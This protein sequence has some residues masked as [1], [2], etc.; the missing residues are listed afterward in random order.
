MISAEMI[1][2]LRTSKTEKLMSIVFGTRI[3]VGYFSAALKKILTS[4]RYFLQK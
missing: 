2:F 1:T 3:L 4:N